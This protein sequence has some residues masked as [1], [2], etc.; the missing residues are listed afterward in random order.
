MIYCKLLQMNTIMKNKTK[1][2][3]VSVVVVSCQFV[4]YV[5]SMHNISIYTWLPNRSSYVYK[6]T[7]GVL[8]HLALLVEA[9]RAC[10]WGALKGLPAVE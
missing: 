1:Q 2:K 5:D 8:H 4:W 10:L 3:H 7:C 9:Q 6:P